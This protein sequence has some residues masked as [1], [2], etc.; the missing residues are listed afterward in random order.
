[1]TAAPL[2]PP[3]Q[4]PRRLLTVAEYLELGETEYRTELVEGQLMMAPRPV[5]KHMEASHVLLAAIRAALPQGYRAL[6]EIDLNL[7]LAPPD[8]PGFVRAPDITVARAEAM[9]QVDQGGGAVRASDV[10][11]V[12]EII[13]P[14]SGRMDRRI[15]REEYADAGIPHYWIVDLSDPISM[16]VCHLAGELGY[17][18][19]GEVTD[20]FRTTKPFPFELDLASLAYD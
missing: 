12:A 8:K 14:G 3:E 7:E 20:T 11:L 10:L 9:R 13:S 17:A 16:L 19:D 15:K 4:W 6:A 5:P 18:D 2:G 1:M